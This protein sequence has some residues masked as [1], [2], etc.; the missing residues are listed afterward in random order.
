MPP[1]DDDNLET[2]IGTPHTGQVRA[3]PIRRPP[4]MA[5]K[6]AQT[7]PLRLANR[8]EILGLLGE[9]GMGSVYKA[10]D[11]ELDEL[12]ALKMLK[13]ELANHEQ[14]V[15][16]FRQEVRLARRIAHANV[17]KTYDLGEAGSQRFLTME[18][19]DGVALSRHLAQRGRLDVLD[20]SLVAAQLCAG[21]SAAHSAGVLH[22]DLKPDNVLVA[23]DGRVAITDFG[24]AQAA[25][26]SSATQ[27]IAG[28]PAYMAPEQLQPSVV[29]DARADLYALGVMLFE[30]LTGKRAWQG[31]ELVSVAMARLLNPPPDPRQHTL[32]PDALAE[33]LMVAMATDRDNRFDSAQ[34]LGNALVQA[35]APGY[36]PK[37]GRPA[38]QRKSTQ[39]LLAATNQTLSGTTQSTPLSQSQVWQHALL[40]IA[41]T[42]AQPV[43]AG[44]LPKSAVPQ[45]G[46]KTLAVMP[47][48]VHGGS[49]Q[50]LGQALTEEIVDA[51]SMT[52][53]LK[54]RHIKNRPETIG[55]TQVLGQSLGV[56]A[57]VSGSLRKFGAKWRLAVRVTA[58]AD[59]FVLWAQ[60]LDSEEGELLVQT[61]GIAKAIADALAVDMTAPDRQ[62]PTDPRATDL[63][64]RGRHALRQ[65]WMPGGTEGLRLLREGLTLAPDDP[66][67]LAA[68]AMAAARQ[69]FYGAAD[70]Q[71]LAHARMAA[72]RAV[73]AAPEL[74]EAWAALAQVQMYSRD[75]PGAARS[76]HTALFRTPGLGWAQAQLGS[77]LLEARDYDRAY[78]H[79]DA[80]RQLDA[81]NVNVQWDIV[82]WHALRGENDT[83]DRLLGQPMTDLSSEISRR[84]AM[85]RLMAWRGVPVDVELP[86]EDLH[87]SPMYKVLHFLL[88][89]Y[90][91]VARGSQVPAMDKELLL[92]MGRQADNPRLRS[93]RCQFATEIFALSGDCDAA[94]QS[95]KDA[96]QSDLHD[97]AW[98][99]DCQALAPLRV[100]PQWSALHK[101]VA[102]RAMRVAAAVIT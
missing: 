28:T 66:H 92:A 9:G 17:V 5:A 88:R 95:L 100:L 18:Y 87:D 78:A 60:K 57:V 79:L 72:D 8:Y 82:R 48:D 6:S 38:A 93:S 20:F 13:P 68:Y 4:S 35:V 94:L 21:L 29:L 34:A 86:P 37:S 16:K 97:Y 14:F 89:Q 90:L 84:F 2:L 74:G 101:V 15:A 42:R 44:P 54:V 25:G 11:L 49:E 30:L 53:G 22:R 64:L 46:A 98:L 67:L 23:R 96:T 73:A 32:V 10:R 71:A 39:E 85:V 47:F 58:V 63:Y 45:S 31:G 83:V 7:G 77:I 91:V 1:P 81:F 70:D 12:V 99:Q 43:L 40:A 56:Q 76:F 26:A 24:I 61:D 52:P 69:G 36:V 55:D 75:L 3:P 50:W 19:I 80:A 33:V 59:G 41:P 102:D 65:E 51:L 27:G 62:A